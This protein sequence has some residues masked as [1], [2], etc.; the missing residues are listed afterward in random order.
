[1]H[2]TKFLTML[3]VGLLIHTNVKSQ[4]ID[5]YLFGGQSN[6]QGVGYTSD[7]P[8]SLRNFPEIELYHSGSVNS[9][10]PANNWMSLRPAGWGGLGAGV[11][12]G[13]E[14]GF[15]KTMLELLDS[16]NI[17]I[18]KHAVGGTGLAVH[19]NPGQHSSDSTN[20]GPQFSSF[21]KTVRAGIEELKQKGLEPNIK[22]MFW[23]QGE[24]DMRDIPEGAG[25]A[26]EEN[27]IHFI[28]RIRQEFLN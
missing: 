14:I 18:I 13:P 21:M 26:C 6:M 28:H 27:L 11:C 1:M 3:L 22:A 12:F 20:F 25:A 15:G 16:P 19:W 7:L 4:D 17:A 5:V 2:K 24:E 23:V 10:A 9:G 8:D